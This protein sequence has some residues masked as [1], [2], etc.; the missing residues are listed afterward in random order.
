MIRACGC[1]HEFQDKLYGPQMRV[2]NKCKAGY[3]CTVC[4]AVEKVEHKPTATAKK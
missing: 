1:K 2:K 4:A 3:R